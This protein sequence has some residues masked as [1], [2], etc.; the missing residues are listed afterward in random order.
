MWGVPGHSTRSRHPKQGWVVGLSPSP[1]ES[2]LI[3][4]ASD[5]KRIIR[6]PVSVRELAGVR[7][8]QTFGVRKCTT[9]AVGPWGLKTNKR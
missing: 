3:W 8:K 2:A 5:F 9:S 1:G 6:H 4:I 7:K